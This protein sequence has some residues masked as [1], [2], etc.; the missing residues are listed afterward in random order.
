MALVKE[1]YSVNGVNRI[2][3]LLKNEAERGIAKEY[4]VKVDA[5]KVVGRNCD[6]ERFFEHE[7][8]LLGN[9]KNITVNIY[10]GSS[11]RC[12]RYMLLLSPEEPSGQELSGI[13]KSINIRLQQEKK[14]WE[15][16]KLKKEN[17]Q[18][19]E[20]LAE[21]GKYSGKLEKH[22]AAFK[23]EK[24]KM[25]SKLTDTLISLAG[26]YISRNP[27]ALNGI[28]I[29]GSILGAG[30]PGGNTTDDTETNDETAQFEGRVTTDT[31]DCTFGPLEKPEYTGKATNVDFE[32]LEEALVPLF[33]EKHRQTVAT[34]VS[35]M[36]HN[37]GIIPE[38]AAL[39]RGEDQ[40]KEG[41]AA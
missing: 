38:I 34:V 24:Q 23:E 29:L 35:V 21:A 6:P 18:L 12:T 17:T 9:S 37:H 11:P 3:Q 33:P 40:A 39:L 36:Y 25:P 28:P 41:K 2:Y 13:E 32:R 7:T 15:Y 31:D 22:I 4:D 16:E 10:D 19:R 26:V 30:Q 27:G 8:F 1:Q 5:L 20:E 14:G